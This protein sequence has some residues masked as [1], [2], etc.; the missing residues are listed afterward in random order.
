M[1]DMGFFKK[2]SNVGITQNTTSLQSKESKKKTIF[3]EIG[4]LR[5]ALIEILLTLRKCKQQICDSGLKIH[6]EC[7][8]VGGLITDFIWMFTY[9]S[10]FKPCNESFLRAIRI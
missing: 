9:T 2:H 3:D 10:F 5:D 7:A 1:N 6:F 4:W 8:W